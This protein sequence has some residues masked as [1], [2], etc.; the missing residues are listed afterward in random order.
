MLRDA[1]EQVAS[2]GLPTWYDGTTLLGEDVRKAA[3]MVA[4]Q[5][6]QLLYE[7]IE[8]RHWLEQRE[9]WLE[10]ARAHASLLTERCAALEAEI[11]RLKSER[12]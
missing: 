5:K 9:Q 11:E 10:D 6:T 8:A 3:M 4:E 7:S 12:K 2:G 1:L